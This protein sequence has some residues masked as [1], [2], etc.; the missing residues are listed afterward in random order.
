MT[1]PPDASPGVPPYRNHSSMA[2]KSQEKLREDSR[3]LG[4]L[5]VPLPVTVRRVG[6]APA[7]APAGFFVP[8][9]C[10]GGNGPCRLLA[11]SN[12]TH[13]LAYTNAVVKGWPENILFLVKV[14]KGNRDGAAFLQ[15]NAIPVFFSCSHGPA[16]PPVSPRKPPAHG[17][18]RAAAPARPS[19]AAQTGGG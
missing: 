10:R 5:R 9:L 6:A 8:D 19:P 12:L 16:A 13:R 1:E 17:A 18:A 2:V 3:G 11:I 7:A 4:R 15:Q 14:T